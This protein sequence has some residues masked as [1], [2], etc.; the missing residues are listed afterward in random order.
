MAVFMAR[1]PFEVRQLAADFQRSRFPVL[2]S[3]LPCNL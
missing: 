1:A 3:Q 2:S